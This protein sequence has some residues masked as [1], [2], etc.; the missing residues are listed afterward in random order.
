MSEQRKI[1]TLRYLISF[2]LAVLYLAPAQVYSQ[3][4]K[5]QVIDMI[6]AKVDDYVVL[7]SD[8]DKAYLEYTSRGNEGGEEVKCGIL[9]SLVV[10]KLLVAKAEIDS[11]E[12]FD[13]EVQMNLDQRMQVIIAQIGSEQR[14]EEYYGKSVEEF[15]EELFDDIREQL[16][17]DKMQRTIT[18]EVDITP[19]EVKKFFN[20]IPGDSLPFLSTEVS[21]GQIVKIPEVGTNQKEKSRQEIL[22]IRRR[23]LKGR[24]MT[25]EY[26]DWT[27]EFADND[28]FI[29]TDKNEQTYSGTW[30]YDANNRLMT[31]ELNEISFDANE[32]QNTWK[33]NKQ[34][35]DSLH[36]QN[37]DINNSSQFYLV[38]SG[39]AGKASPVITRDFLKGQ[40]KVVKFNANGESFAA[41][42]REFSD[43]PGSAKA[44]GELGYAARG[45]MVPEFEA[46]AMRMKPGEISQPI[47]TDFG[48]HLIQL[49]DRRG[50]E[51]NARHI[52]V[53]PDFSALDF[54]TAEEFL[55]SL[56][57]LILNDSL[58]FEKSA[59]EYSDDDETAG[60]GGFL[61]DATGS[62]SVSVEDLD[63]VIFF[64]IDTME[65]GEISKPLRYR[66]RDGKEAVRIL[67]YK[68]KIS[69]HQASLKEDYQ[70]IKLAALNQKKQRILDNW[71]DE[72]KNEVF[73]QIDDEYKPCAI[74]QG[75]R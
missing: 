31:L 40:W 72:A 46:A 25:S 26:G 10:N 35:A 43:D 59:K 38:K 2:I 12:V 49:I 57:T 4:R 30:K 6:V 22:D 5:G 52:L 53:R 24:D 8:L 33:L 34:G 60:N 27:L 11:V 32:F 42:A 70:K 65:V 55:D 7:K 16:V 36:F 13:E 21:V 67:Y 74:L 45:T 51:F 44:G 62:S 17:A 9:E 18:S 64:T 37:A 19:S 29:L 66:M 50:N 20:N 23:I 41:L 15:E 39:S 75:T 28:Q 63:P 56:R 58:V 68:A 47:E 61:I 14:L 48:Y 71:F 3:A 69:P 54:Q 1:T 73:I